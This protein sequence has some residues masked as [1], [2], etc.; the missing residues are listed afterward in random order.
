MAHPQS[1]TGCKSMT[2]SKTDSVAPQILLVPPQSKRKGFKDGGTHRRLANSRSI[3][4][5]S[6]PAGNHHTA[7]L[8]S[9]P[10]AAGPGPGCCHR[11]EQVGR[12][13]S[14]SPPPRP[15]APRSRRWCPAPQPC[16]HTPWGECFLEGLC[17]E[18][19]G[20]TRGGKTKGGM[21]WKHTCPQVNQDRWPAG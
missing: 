18:S 12:T 2:R 13:L 7:R 21:R 6:R 3:A 15:A 4:V 9:A 16:P 5:T 14:Q 10:R 1:P 17:G 20:Q 8:S 11:R 19:S